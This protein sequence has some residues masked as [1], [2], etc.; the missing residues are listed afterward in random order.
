MRTS[1]YLVCL[2][3]FFAGCAGSAPAQP[4]MASSEDISVADAVSLLASDPDVVVLDIRTP[5]E[6]AAGHIDGAVMIDCKSED[7]TDRLRELDPSK[8]YVMH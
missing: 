7:F 4:S 5:G 8:T 6:Y 2:A 3:I 1:N